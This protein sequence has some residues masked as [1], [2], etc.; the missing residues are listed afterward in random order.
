MGVARW[1]EGRFSGLTNTLATVAAQIVTRRF[2]LQGDSLL[3]NV[4]AMER[5]AS[6]TVEL[7]AEL[8]SRAPRRPGRLW[9]VQASRRP[10]LSHDHLT[11]GGGGGAA[12]QSER[13]ILA[14]VPLRRID[15][16]AALVTWRTAAGTSTQIDRALRGELVRL[17]FLLRGGTPSSVVLYAFRVA[18]GVDDR[19]KAT[20]DSKL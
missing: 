2:R 14:S 4:K 9:G 10:K 12:E 5:G 16:T 11:Y 15:E 17:R 7:V 18:S 20:A 8:D 6:C 13:R 1:V 19:S 3:L